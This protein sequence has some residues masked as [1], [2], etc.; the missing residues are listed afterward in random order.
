MAIYLQLTF[1]H[2]IWD[3]K[4]LEAPLSSLLSEII[5]QSGALAYYGFSSKVDAFFQNF[6]MGSHKHR[7][8]VNKDYFPSLGVVVLLPLLLN[9]WLYTS[10]N[11]LISYF[12]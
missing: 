7:N 10:E 8:S 6:Q 12:H 5:S 2:S 9:F 11:F 1:I 3:R 4:G